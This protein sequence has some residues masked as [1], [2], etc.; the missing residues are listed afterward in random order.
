MGSLRLQPRAG[1]GQPP[2]GWT[3][4]GG[5]AAGGGGA[6]SLEVQASLDELRAEVLTLRK[7]V[8]TLEK[9]RSDWRAEM[10]VFAGQL[11][12]LHRRLEAVAFEIQRGTQALGTA[13]ALAERALEDERQHHATWETE[14]ERQHEHWRELAELFGA[15]LR[16]ASAQHEAAQADEAAQAAAVERGIASLAE[17]AQ[18]NG[19]LARNQVESLRAALAQLAELEQAGAD[20]V[21][22]ALARIE[23]GERGMADALGGV[24]ASASRL[25]SQTAE[26]ASDQHEAE[27]RQARIEAHRENQLGLKCLADGNWLAAVARFEAASSLAPSA[28]APRF[29]LAYTHYRRGNPTA[30]IDLL[31]PLAAE[32]PGEA[33][34]GF[35]RGLVR[36]DLGDLAGARLDLSAV[37]G[38]EVRN[39]AILAAA[40][41]T[42]LLDRDPAAAVDVFRRAVQASRSAGPPPPAAPFGPI[43]PP[44]GP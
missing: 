33:P 42:H 36:L 26:I 13:A 39:P 6:V 28:L 44:A 17:G 38:A 2:L 30:A 19:D 8:D 4:G 34:V 14:T 32:F 37:A 3:P 16:Q 23:A 18:H 21:A 22:R 12:D 5:G 31:D 35:L 7:K 43:P 25:A 10:G 40:G 24:G 1:S 41:C 9:E 11:T 15:A 27:E 20:G 29:N